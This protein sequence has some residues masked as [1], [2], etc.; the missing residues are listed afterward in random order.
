MMKSICVENFW[1]NCKKYMYMYIL[2]PITFKK[3]IGKLVYFDKRPLT[4]LILAPLYN[5]QGQYWQITK[6]RFL[7]RDVVLYFYYVCLRNCPEVEGKVKNYIT[8]S[9]FYGILCDQKRV[10]TIFWEKDLL[11][12]LVYSNFYWSFF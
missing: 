6:H 2:E 7:K 1:K 9:H 12:D 4:S 5:R 10:F 11:F 3:Q 8:T